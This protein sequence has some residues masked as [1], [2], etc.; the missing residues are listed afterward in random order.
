MKAGKHFFLQSFVYLCLMYLLVYGIT[1]W[2]HNFSISLFLSQL[3]GIAMLASLVFLCSKMAILGN[4]LLSVFLVASTLCFFIDLVCSIIFDTPL[5][6]A[7][8][9]TVLETNLGETLSFS[10]LY[11]SKI[12]I[13]CGVFMFS[14]CILWFISRYGKISPKILNILALLGFPILIY[15]TY[16]L[17]NKV[18]CR[19][20]SIFSFVLPFRYGCEF[21]G[22]FEEISNAKKAFLND[23]IL[24]VESA[25]SPPPKLIR[26]N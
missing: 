26:S 1:N 24:L 21:Y 17:S 4:I 18:D 22:A 3:L 8:I 10:S 14:F 13:A 6:S 23:Q 5:T 20:N 9:F 2:E 16:L 12:G 11:A 7:M 15:Q 19:F 25:S